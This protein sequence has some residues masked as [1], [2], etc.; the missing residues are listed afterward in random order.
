MKQSQEKVLENLEKV[1]QMID[2]LQ[3][4]VEVNKLLNLLY[5]FFAQKKLLQKEKVRES[6]ERVLGKAEFLEK[7]LQ[8]IE[9]EIL[10]QPQVF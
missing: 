5:F 6:Q 2:H 8:T 1:E 4:D 10:V 3:N 9:K 7:R